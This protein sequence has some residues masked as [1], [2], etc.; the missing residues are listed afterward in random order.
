MPVIDLTLP[1]E[2]A[3]ALAEFLKRAGYSDYRALAVNEQQ[4][5]DMQ[6][7]GEQL[8]QALAERGY[9]PR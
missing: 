5:Y 2:Q 4:A 8:R 1:D 7:A 6:A 3:M 9:A